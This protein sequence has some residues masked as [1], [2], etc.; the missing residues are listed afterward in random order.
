MQVL[1]WC[2]R[3]K[4]GS[5]PRFALAA[6][7][8]YTLLMV[9]KTKIDELREKIAELNKKRD[10]IIMEKGLAA[11]ANKDLRENSLFDY[12][13]MKERNLTIQINNLIHEIQD[14]YKKEHS[15]KR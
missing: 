13:E 11:E 6:A 15:N 4:F 2:K 3:T 7:F 14:L 10:E 9:E 1:G 5:D 8:C 12:C